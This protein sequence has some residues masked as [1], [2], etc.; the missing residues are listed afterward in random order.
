MNYIT[1]M[2]YT[3]LKKINQKFPEFKGANWLIRIPLAIIFIQQGLDKLPF[4]PSTAEA[5]EL[6]LI[7]W[8]MVISSELLAGFGL[9]L[10][11]ILQ[12]LK[13][14]NL[15]GDFL[16]RFSGAIMVCII[17]GVI[18]LSDPESFIEI[19]LYDHIHVMLYCGGLFFALRG[20]RAK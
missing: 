16:T 5:Y 1:I 15:I 18:I 14:L 10:G 6:P 3:K 8:L 17:T 13:I 12:S 20:N 19:L 4:D 9:L 7:V 2:I 11:G